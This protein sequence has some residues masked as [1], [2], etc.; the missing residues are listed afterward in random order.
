MQALL[1]SKCWTLWVLGHCH[2]EGHTCTLRW[3]PSAQRCD[4]IISPSIYTVQIASSSIYVSI[5]LGR[6]WSNLFLL[7][8][9]FCSISIGCDPGDASCHSLNEALVT[10][11]QLELPRVGEEFV[12]V[13]PQPVMEAVSN[14]EEISGTFTV[15]VST[16]GFSTL[17]VQ[18]E[19]IESGRPMILEIQQGPLQQFNEVHK[20]SRVETY[21]VLM[22]LDGIQS[23][24]LLQKKMCDELPD[25][26]FLTVNRPK[27]VQVILSKAGA[28]GMKLAYSRD[29]LGVMVSGLEASG[30]IPE[31]NAQHISHAVSVGDRIIELNGTSYKGSELAKRLERQSQV[32][33]LTVLQYPSVH[34]DMPI[35]AGL[36]RQCFNFNWI[37][38]SRLGTYPNQGVF[39]LPSGGMSDSSCR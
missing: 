2:T 29:S 1:A 27:R 30:Q 33:I 21:D 25:Q 31:W 19:S 36:S 22:A 18:W 20:S 32:K 17:G 8:L 26:L 34:D 9:F 24:D 12:Q 38:T 10:S 35:L 23:L 15:A 16:K 14:P 13:A 4:V 39:P 5:W 28:M 6:V 37:C 3:S 7:K 11:S